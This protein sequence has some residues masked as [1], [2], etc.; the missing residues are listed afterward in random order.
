M[1]KTEDRIHQIEEFCE[2][3]RLYVG[4]QSLEEFLADMKTI[5]AISMMVIAISEQALKLPEAFLEKNAH[6]PWHK[7]IGMRHRLAHDYRALNVP[8]LY[9]VATEDIPSLLEMLRQ[10][11]Y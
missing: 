1:A 11:R 5:D 8:L 6:I 9:T 7:I 3:V 2:R 4:S 10:V